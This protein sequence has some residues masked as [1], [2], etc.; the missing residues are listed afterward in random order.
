MSIAPLAHIGGCSVYRVPLADR[1]AHA[2]RAELPLGP[3][4]IDILSPPCDNAALGECIWPQIIEWQ[5]QLGEKQYR[6]I[7]SADDDF[8]DL[9]AILRTTGAGMQR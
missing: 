6:L 8:T 4:I 3:K 7:E 2:D 9:N 1:S 5:S